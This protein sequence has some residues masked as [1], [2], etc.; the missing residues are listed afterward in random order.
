M[1]ADGV[2]RIDVSV[3][4]HFFCQNFPVENAFSGGKR[5]PEEYR[6]L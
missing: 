3:L 6:L 4:Y 5:R 2:A 1:S